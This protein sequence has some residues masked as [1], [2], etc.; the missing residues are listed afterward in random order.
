[1]NTE[2]DQWHAAGRS[3]TLWWR[4]DDAIAPSTALDR[5]LDLADRHGVGI[6]LAVIPKPATVELADALAGRQDVDV[7]QHG[8]AHINHAGPDEKK[9][10]LGDH[11]PKELIL[12]QLR[13]GFD[14]LV[15]M[16]GR[17][18]QAVLVPPWNRVGRSIAP[19]LSALGYGG[20]SVFDPR[21]RREFSDGV[22][23][24]NTHVDPVAWRGN[25]GFAGDEKTLAAMTQHLTDRRMHRVDANE[26]TGLLTHHLVHDQATWRFIDRCLGLLVGHEA[27]RMLS[28]REIFAGAG[29]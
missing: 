20:I 4:D 23:I 1:M 8:W 14:R 7:L 25:R 3:A 2:L 26:P 22:Q 28:A 9:M 15:D 18:F 24:V 16:F 11:R 27:V 19:G 21:K 17:K 13:R 6:S 12:D 5:L 10:E 29:P